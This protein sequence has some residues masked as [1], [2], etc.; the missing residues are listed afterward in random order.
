MKNNLTELVF[1]LDRSGSMAGLERDTIG[2]FNSMLEKQRCAPGRCRITTVLF[3]HRYEL[4]HDRQSIDRV[5][6]LDEATYFVRGTTALMDAVGFTIQRIAQAQQMAAPED[7]ADHVMFVSITDGYENASRTFTRP[8]IQRMIRFERERY[9]WE[10]LF[11]GAN[12]DAEATA[13]AMGIAPERAVNYCAD[14]VGTRKNFDAV[15]EAAVNLRCCR[16]VGSDW[17]TTID[18]DYQARGGGRK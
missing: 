11:L 15:S 4:V 8:E 5:A 10:F 13:G 14:S 18:E 12:I 17:R 2:G 7:R 16:P 6:P 3:D 1:V 9:D